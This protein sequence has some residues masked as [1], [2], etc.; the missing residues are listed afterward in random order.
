M[1]TALKV[2]VCLFGGIFLLLGLAGMFT[3]ESFANGLGLNIANPEGSGSVRTMIG[4]HYVAMGG[5]CIYAIVK[6][7]PVLL[8]PVAAIEAVMVVARGLAAVNG[9][10]SAATLVP[11]TIE[12]AA[13]V[14]LTLAAMRLPAAESEWFSFRISPISDSD[15]DQIQGSSAV[16]IAAFGTLINC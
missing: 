7:M 13:A 3:P 1:T 12:I 16:F 4:A 14:V 10:F 11:T 15:H 6:Q 9:E 8:L 5:V 2:L